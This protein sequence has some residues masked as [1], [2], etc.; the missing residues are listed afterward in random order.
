MGDGEGTV[1]RGASVLGVPVRE[2]GG[3]IL[4]DGR[5]QRPLSQLRQVGGSGFSS[6][7]RPGSSV[8]LA[9]DGGVVEP[10]VS[11]RS[12]MVLADGDGADTSASVAGSS[13]SPSELVPR[14]TSDENPTV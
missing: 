6:D 9:F 2:R 13:L 3:S 7:T 5:L 4:G 11:L 12:G 1:G 8:V 14:C 10:S